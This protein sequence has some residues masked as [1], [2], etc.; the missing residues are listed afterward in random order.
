MT[1]TPRT[2]TSAGLLRVQLS[3]AF[4]QVLSGINVRAA[5]PVAREHGEAGEHRTFSEVSTVALE[6]KAG[7]V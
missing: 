2:A 3:S 7:P 6:L 4:H 1:S 5:R